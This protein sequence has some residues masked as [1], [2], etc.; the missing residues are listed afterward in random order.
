MK[1]A[2]TFT[3]LSLAAATS[4]RSKV[5]NSLGLS[6]GTTTSL[7]LDGINVLYRGG[8]TLVTGRD[9]TNQEL[10][11]YYQSLSDSDLDGVY[12]N[13]LYSSDTYVLT[14]ADTSTPSVDENFPNA[15]ALV[16]VSVLSPAFLFLSSSLT[17]SCFL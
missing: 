1:Q 6:Y 5:D 16:S 11:I 12:V 17:Y 2:I 9:T 10:K 13:A 8:E 4:S 14:P 3:A 7:S 15:V